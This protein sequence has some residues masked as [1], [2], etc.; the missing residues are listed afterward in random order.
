MSARSAREY[1]VLFSETRGFKI[2]LRAKSERAAIAAAQKLW[3]TQGENAFTC[4]LGETDAWMAD[5]E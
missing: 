2:K 4:F 1:R 3:D 5:Q